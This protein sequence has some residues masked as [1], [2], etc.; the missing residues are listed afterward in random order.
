MAEVKKI[1]SADDRLKFIGL[2]HLAAEHV[3]EAD[4]IRKALG[5]L[6]GPESEDHIS[7]HLYGVYDPDTSTAALDELLL[8]IGIGVDEAQG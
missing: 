4:R 7:D 8:K 5:R 3:R 6:L 1:I 2:C